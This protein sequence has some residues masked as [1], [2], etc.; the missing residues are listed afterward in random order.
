VI[1]TVHT[2]SRAAA[3][4]LGDFVGAFLGIRNQKTRIQKRENNMLTDTAVRNAKLTPPRKIGDGGGLYLEITSTK[5]KLWRM[6]YRFNGKQRTLY[7]KGAYPQ[8][9][10]A[11]AR[12]QRDQAKELILDWFLG[13]IPVGVP[14]SV[15][16]GFLAFAWARRRARLRA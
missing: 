16:I 6:A 15:A 4:F 5:S 9:T 7:I 13:M 3:I 12:I 8:V 1:G 14:I 11:D 10:L 2:R